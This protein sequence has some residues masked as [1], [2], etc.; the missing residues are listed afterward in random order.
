MFKWKNSG[1][2]IL[3]PHPI[4]CLFFLFYVLTYVFNTR[5]QSQSIK[6]NC[7]ALFLIELTV[8][9]LHI[10]VKTPWTFSGGQDS[11]LA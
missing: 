9:L 5:F 7:F 6:A 10:A 3:N 2:H 1:F 4:H 8:A 11:Y